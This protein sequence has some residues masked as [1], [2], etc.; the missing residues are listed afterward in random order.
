M[1]KVFSI[2]EQNNGDVNIH[3]TSA[4]R[5]F[6]SDT[7]YD[8]VAASED[9]FEECEKHISIHC[10]PNSNTTNTIKQTIVTCNSTK[11]NVQVSTGIKADKKFIPIVFRV[12]G[13][14]L[15]DRYLY[16]QKQQENLVSLGEYNP[17]RDQLRL[18][19]FISENNQIFP[20]DVEHPSNYKFIELNNFRI[21]LLWSYF[22]KPSH[23]HAID[24]FIQ[25]QKENGPIRGLE[26]FEI[27]NLYTNINKTY[28]D[29]YFKI[30]G[31]E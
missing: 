30:Y 25:T 16:T 11:T 14:Q 8:L 22:N 3:T 2:V 27:Y 12:C 9:V 7:I 20:Q 31:D 28:I 18:F 21:H 17:L 6:V 10:N 19:M 1:S 15:R 5:S 4:G 24:F 13:N 26:W 23:E 29:E